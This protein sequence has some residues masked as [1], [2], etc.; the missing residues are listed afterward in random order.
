MRTKLNKSSISVISPIILIFMAL[1]AAVFAVPVRD[2]KARSSTTSAN[3]PAA[4]N[5]LIANGG[6]ENSFNGWTTAGGPWIATPLAHTG[7]NS[8]VLGGEDNANHSFY[9]DVSLAADATSATLSFWWYV[10]TQ[11][12][13]GADD[14]FYMEVIDWEGGIYQFEELSNSSSTGG[15]FKTTI[16]LDP[17]EFPTFFG[18]PLRIR[19]RATTDGADFTSF[20]IDD[21]QLVVCSPDPACPYDVYES[22]DSMVEAAPIPTAVSIY[23]LYI[24]PQEDE[25]W[26]EFS[27]SSGEIIDVSL[28]NL[29]ADYDLE[30][31][32]ANGILLASS[33]SGGTADEGVQ[34]VAASAGTYHVHVFG[35]NGAWST[36]EYV[37]RV[38]LAI[39]PTD[40]PTATQTPTDTPSATPTPSPTATHTPTPTPACPSDSYEPNETFAQAA[41]IETNISHYALYICLSGDEDWFKFDVSQG[42]IID[43]SLYN[44]PADYNLQLLH[45]DGGVLVTASHSG[46]VDEV[47]SHIAA[48]SGQ[49]R[50]VV[51]GQEGAWSSEEYS[52]RIDL[53]ASPTDTPTPTA[54]ATDTPTATSTPTPTDTP[55]PRPATDTPTPTHTFTP[56]PAPSD[57]PT[58]TPTPTFTPTPKP[59]TPTI[60]ATPTPG[61]VLVVNTTDDTVDAARCTSSHCSLQEAVLA[62][63]SRG[64]VRIEFNIPT[65]DSGYNSADEF[66]KIDLSFA[67]FAL[68]K[69][70]ITIDGS[71]Q[72]QNLS[73]N[74]TNA[75]PAPA[76]EINGSAFDSDV[77]GFRISADNIEINGLSITGFKRC[78]IT[79]DDGAQSSIISGNYIGLSPAG[80]VKANG[81]GIEVTRASYTI[82]GGTAPGLGNVISG[83]NGDGIQFIVNNHHSEVLGNI[84]GLGPDGNKHRPNSGN[85]ISLLWGSQ[86]NQIGAKGDYDGNVISANQG[87]G[88]YLSGADVTLN[89]I[90]GNIIGLDA[91]GREDAGN[92]GS[93]IALDGDAFRNTIGVDEEGGGNLIAGNG[94]HGIIAS[95]GNLHLIYNNF[96]GTN[97]LGDS[98]LPN[99]KAGIRLDNGA[100]NSVVANNLISGNKG[101]GLEMRGP[102][103]ANNTTTG[104]K[105]GVGKSGRYGIAN[106][107][108]GVLVAYGAHDNSVTDSLIS[109]NQKNGIEILFGDTHTNLIQGN[110]IG[111]DARGDGILGNWDNGIEIS[112]GR[113]NTLLGNLIGGNGDNGIYALSSSSHNNQILANFIGTNRSEQKGLANVQHGIYLSQGAHHQLIGPY[114]D[115]PNRIM[116]NYGDGVRVDG[117]NTDANTITRNAIGN[118][119]DQ[120]IVVENGGNNYI[121][122]PQI[123]SVAL[124]NSDY[125][126]EGTAGPGNKVELFSDYWDESLLFEGETVADGSGKFSAVIDVRARN[127]TATQTDEA[128]NTSALSAARS[129]A[130]PDGFE[131]NDTIWTAKPMPNTLEAYICS[132]DDIDYYAI[133]IAGSI[134]PLRILQV[135]MEHAT[136]TYALEI[137]HDNGYTVAAQGIATGQ[138]NTVIASLVGGETQT[139]LIK[140][141]AGKGSADPRRAY[142]L[143]AY[144]FDCSDSYEPNDSFG[145]A[146]Q[147][148]GGS[149]T[150]IESYLC[151]SW[152]TDI[153]KFKASTGQRIGLSMLGY[154]PDYEITLFDPWQNKIKSSGAQLSH[155]AVING[156]Y[157]VR[158][159]SSSGWRYSPTF[160]YELTVTLGNKP[161][162]PERDLRLLDMEVNQSIQSLSNTIPLISGKPAWAR[163]YVSGFQH[164]VNNVQGYL[165]AELDGVVLEPAQFPCSNTVTAYGV[166][167][168]TKSMRDNLKSSINCLLPTSWLANAGQLE[169]TGHVYSSDI[170]DP[171]NGNNNRSDEL[172]VEES[173]PLH[174]KI[175]QVRDSCEPNKCEEK[176]GPSFKDYADVDELILRMYPLAEVDLIP[177]AGAFVRWEDE[178][179]TLDALAAEHPN[180]ATDPNTF[181]MGAVRDSVLWFGRGLGFIGSETNG[182]GLA[183]WVEVGAGERSQK[184]AAHE[185][186]HNLRLNHVNGCWPNVP[187]GPYDHFRGEPH[188]DDGDVQHT[189]GLDVFA[190]PPEVIGPKSRHEIMT[191]CNGKQWISSTHYATL[192]DALRIGA[193]MPVAQTMGVDDSNILIISGRINIETGAV[194][195]RPLTR[196]PG[197]ELSP[198]T[199]TNGAGAYRL[200]LLDGGGDILYERS[201][202]LVSGNHQESGAPLFLMVPDQPDM[203]RLVVLSGNDAIFSLDASAHAP[204]VSLQPV[205]GLAPERL[206][207]SWTAEDSDDDKLT[208]WLSFSPDGGATWQPAGSALTGSQTEIDT[209]LWPQTEQG[210]LRIQVSDGVN[211]AEAISGPFAVS[212]KIPVLFITNPDA[213]EAV[214]PGWPVSFSA[215]GYDAEDG[216]LEADSITWNSNRDGELGTGKQIIVLDLSAGW[217]TITATMTDS[218]QN[219]VSES[220]QLFVGHEIY[221]PVQWQP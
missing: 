205:Q 95:A 52:L 146:S 211:T 141:T 24:C 104:N 216:S 164:V 25:D 215:S 166:L 172:T 46:D 169:L 72:K 190:N 103:T 125:R 107:E 3:A 140:V 159:Q 10:Y 92:G 54:A 154:A 188:L 56:T 94:E 2:S 30:L 65:T 194:Q 102:S 117:V 148:P 38:D 44:L 93:G 178:D 89:A 183:S 5:D 162:L 80:D 189:Y 78:G 67:A 6:F 49:Y 173:P 155:D 88:I 63:N 99:D 8:G 1:I 210:L 68:L 192:R 47:I 197:S 203:R 70:R 220:I 130:C 142:M 207:V 177:H 175:I 199:A 81:M 145:F 133:E 96:V 48:V 217:H 163:L 171:N 174:I 156:D 32:D 66:W 139:L 55:T 83:N 101:N 161:A 79:T 105:I 176:H 149:S 29:P 170:V 165:S 77:C 86:Q 128:G 21:V 115:I 43:I 138:D 53:N 193:G 214:T 127:V 119:E 132:Q 9:Q 209:T 37:L 118:N 41:T 206:N 71:S 200:R 124:A 98:A 62:A 106:G 36:T 57:T 116:Y 50:T 160:P 185:L 75:I 204:T 129:I 187:D 110:H 112:G 168:T 131:T 195:L 14:L 31:Y 221:T 120:G 152:D 100:N 13:E 12:G 153:Y 64:A 134:T 135:E 180:F 39:P 45:P 61:Q 4:C 121:Q 73:S 122:P 218:D 196:Y 19:F 17:T 108:N 143:T 34:H 157:F 191:Y 7:S 150:T 51:Y 33:A 59:P 137:L 23:S 179:P 84:I 26:Y 60:T 144:T 182:N 35:Y 90:I 97:D 208:A 91:D 15:W 111:V 74:S 198:Y 58:P 20:Y 18:A 27:V 212:A 184:L 22:N 82:I 42:E 136:E 123:T 85:G 201:F 147:L 28:Y 114:N 87:H 76:I 158:V 11:E 186:G 181:I 213:G 16:D 126:I 151:R 109:A 40:T 219:T 202:A 69:D 113:N 167:E